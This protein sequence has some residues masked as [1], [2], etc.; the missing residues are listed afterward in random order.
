MIYTYILYIICNYYL[1]YAD[2]KILNTSCFGA[3]FMIVWLRP[4]MWKR[5][6]VLRDDHQERLNFE[7]VPNFGKRS[8]VITNFYVLTIQVDSSRSI[9]ICLEY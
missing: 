3:V 2:Y 5:T 8:Y 4:N 9:V 1:Q 6:L 7:T